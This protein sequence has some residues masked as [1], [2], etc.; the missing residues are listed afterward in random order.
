[1]TLI[2]LLQSSFISLKKEFLYGIFL[3]K[4]IRLHHLFRVLEARNVFFLMFCLKQS[5]KPIFPRGRV[6][7]TSADTGGGECQ[8]LQ[9]RE[10]SKK[11]QLC[12][13]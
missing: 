10:S 1:M 2:Y 6:E 5:K 13:F 7:Q 8:L 12:N 4:P 11:C 3:S 9:Q